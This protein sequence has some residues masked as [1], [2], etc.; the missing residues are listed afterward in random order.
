MF[1]KRKNNIFIFFFNLRIEIYCTRCTEVSVRPKPKPNKM[2]LWY[3]NEPGHNIS[4][5]IAWAPGEASDQPAHLGNLIKV[6]AE[7][8]G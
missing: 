6:S 5:K 3:T 4:H 7:L 1:L 2:Q 8:S